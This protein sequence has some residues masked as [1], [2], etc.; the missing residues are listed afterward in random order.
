MA[1]VAG[2]RLGPYEILGLLGV[3]GMGEVY[4]A[5]DTRLGRDVAVKVL[6]ASLASEPERRQRF[7]QEARAEAV[8]NHPNVLIVHDVGTH[9]GTPY[10]VTEL[11]EGESLRERLKR[12]ALSLPVAVDVAFQLAAG[13]AAAHGKGIV[14]R[15]LKP[16]NVFLVRD[17]PVKILD[18]GVAKL[19]QPL[20]SL[21][22]EELSVAE[23]QARMTG[24]GLIVGTLAYM[25]PE[26]ARG[27]VVDGRSDVFSLGIVLYEMITGQDPFRRPSAV[28]TLSAILKEMPPP[29]HTP[30]GRPPAEL[31]RILGRALAKAPVD[32]Y[33]DTRALVEDLG[34]VKRR[35]EVRLLSVPVIALAVALVLA[36][37]GG[38]LWLSRRGPPLQPAANEPV[39]FLVADLDN[40]TG[41]AVFDGALEQAL[42]IGL[43][44]APFVTS[45]DRAQ[46][47]RQAG[48]LGGGGNAP[49]LDEET[50]RLVSESLGIKLVVAESLDRH[51]DAYELE[52]RVVDPV[53]SQTVAAARFKA[54]SKA[55]VLKAV[56]AVA[57]RLRRQLGDVVPTSAGAFERETFT[58]ASLDA[59]GSYARAQELHYQG[60]SEEAAQEYRKAIAQDPDFGRA[61][62]GLAALL[63]NQGERDKSEEYFQ[64][65]LALLDRMTERERYRTRGLYYILVQDHAKAIEEYQRLIDGFP[66]D[67]AG[68]ANLAFAYF[69][70][71]DMERALTEGR[72]AVEIYPKNAPTRLNLA[73]YAMYAGE[74]E[75]AEAEARAVLAQN[76]SYAK[77][78]VAVALAQLGQGRIDEARQT[79]G[80]L[81][82]VSAR[83]ASFAAMG[84]ADIALYEG[85][86][87]EAAAIL[88]K[89]IAGDVANEY[90]TPAA[91][92]TVTLARVHLLTGR[93]SEALRAVESALAR[94]R[95][96][97]VAYPAALVLIGAGQPSR[98]AGIASELESRLEADPRAYAKLVEG[99]IAL[100]KGDAR[101]ALG[102]FQEAR[103]I[104]DTWLGR[105]ALARADLDA[106]ALAAA[107][108]ELD[109]CLKRRGEAMAVFL[110][111]VP[112][113]WY[114]PP[115]YY[116]LGRVQQGLHS[117]RFVD[118]LRTFCDIKRNAESGDSLV[119]DAR[120]RLSGA[121]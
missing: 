87:G 70:A 55:D 46:A 113:Y 3:G 89:G 96:T 110:D 15:D 58:T 38:A 77:A 19:L 35:Y 68:H 52:T 95:Q 48:T 107:H 63:Y 67:S 117:A 69:L 75:T 90:G 30:G 84:L 101:V 106:G 94:S 121:P 57:V 9:D 82:G 2:E 80:Q 71:R 21:P 88:K 45:F 1:F 8:I 11:L 79:Y 13:L 114:F 29:L 92:K 24:Q 91:V 37:A 100:A 22:P 5:R 39:S 33:G 111:D 119:D 74:L 116:H 105:L 14:H 118:S 16:E 41:E 81:E 54:E 4:R 66:A 47:R 86:L 109:L 28:D 26:Q 42:V 6:P 12:G 112:S 61:Y 50:A 56:D 97:N 49:R 18:F 98:A 32:R 10:L 51:G 104:A 44:G 20:T 72:R 108:S 102:R 36:V 53:T 120:R 115:V 17:G 62:C 65:A 27:E 60:R 64:K 25:S 40:R 43:E 93:R 23:T 73:L 85:R 99:E 31:H 78:L 59:M 76:P 103:D 34:R 7:E 83:G